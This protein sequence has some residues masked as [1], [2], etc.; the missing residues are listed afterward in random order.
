MNLK[1]LQPFYPMR[2]MVKIL[3]RVDELTRENTSLRKQLAE[4][5]EQ[6]EAAQSENADLTA[7]LF[8]LQGDY[9]RQMTA[10]RVLPIVHRLEN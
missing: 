1:E 5:R 9:A 6:F 4:T 2:D 10:A 7:Q 3:R 8:D